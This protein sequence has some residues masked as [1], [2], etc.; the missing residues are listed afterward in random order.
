MIGPGRHLETGHQL[1]V[2]QLA[3]A[4]VQVVIV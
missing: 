1:P 4:V 3:A 2:H